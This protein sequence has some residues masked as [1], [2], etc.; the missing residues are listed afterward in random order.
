MTAIESFANTGE[1]K[2]ITLSPLRA[3]PLVSVLMA[4]YNYA[5]YIEEAIESVFH[6]SYSNWE[7]LICDDGSTDGS[8]DIIKKFVQLD[9]R[10]RL[11]SKPNG[12][13]AS[14][15]NAAYALSKGEVVCLLDSDDLYLPTK[16]E[17]IIGCCQRHPDR[18]LIVHRIIR[19]DQRRRRRGVWPLLHPLPDG[20]YGARLLEDSGILAFSPPTS[21]LSLRRDLAQRLFPVPTRSPL[22]ACPDQVIVRLAPLITPVGSVDKALAEYRLHDTNSYGSSGVTAASLDRDVEFCQAL[23]KEQHSFLSQLSP[24]VAAKLIPLN[25]ANYIIFIE[26]LRAKL[27]NDPSARRLYEKYIATFRK[28]PEALVTWFWRFSFY[29]PTW[30]FERA[31]NLFLGQNLAKRIV[32]RLKGLA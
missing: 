16:L 9:P 19:V 18:G 7:L 2:P 24:L 30:L 22:H 25:E 14:A 1:L 11:I 12:G 27:R 32:A 3:R 13:H 4:N 31:I 10:V 6:Q 29:L 21:G 5:S 15:L 20:W 17:A 8:L 28:Q 23:W 26:Y